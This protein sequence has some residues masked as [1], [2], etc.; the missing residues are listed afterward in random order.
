M[1]VPD[2]VN[3][4][5]Y[6]FR[7]RRLK[8]N[9]YQTAWSEERTVIPD[10]GQLPS[11]PVLQGV[12]RQQS[13]AIVCFDPVR[14][15]VGYI[16]EYRQAGKSGSD[17]GTWTKLSIPTAQSGYFYLSGLLQSNLYQFRI[18][19]LSAGGKSDFSPVVE[20]RD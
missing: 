11:V 12:I 10:G 20:A 5:P 9:N 3:G 6:S 18:A 1:F 17:T 8:H 14:K 15:A 13:G 2:L 4:Q 19:A 7:L 16:L